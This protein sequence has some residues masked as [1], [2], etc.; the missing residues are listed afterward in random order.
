MDD[1]TVDS[2]WSNEVCCVKESARILGGVSGPIT[3][4]HHSHLGGAGSSLRCE[5]VRT[6][7]TGSPVAGNS[8]FARELQE[9][10]HEIIR[11]RSGHNSFRI[12]RNVMKY[13]S[14]PGLFAGVWTGVLFAFMFSVDFNFLL[15]LIFG[16]VLGLVVTVVFN[17]GA[18]TDQEPWAKRARNKGE[19]AV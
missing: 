10:E 3:I 4:T 13:L 14:T 12:K 18:P 19:T 6:L 1:L 8:E 9:R 16:L 15:A 11:V 17:L 7:G 5:Y 2:S